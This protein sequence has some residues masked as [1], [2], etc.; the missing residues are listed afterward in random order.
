MKNHADIHFAKIPKGHFFLICPLIISHFQGFYPFI[1]VNNFVWEWNFSSEMGSYRISKAKVSCA[2]KYRHF[3]KLFPI[4]NAAA[5]TSIFDW[6]QL[7]DTRDASSCHLIN[8]LNCDFSFSASS[9]WFFLQTWQ[10]FQNHRAQRDLSMSSEFVNLLTFTYNNTSWLRRRKKMPFMALLRVNIK[11]ENSLP[12][13]LVHFL[14]MR[15][16]FHQNRAKS[17]WKIRGRNFHV[18]MALELVLT[19]F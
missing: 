15:S 2:C 17:I 12:S 19:G 3:S 4:L 7:L 13:N 1:M 18:K 14:W 16:I 5:R 10:N 9:F 6:C 8:E 11:I